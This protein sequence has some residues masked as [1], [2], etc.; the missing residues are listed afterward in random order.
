MSDVNTATTSNGKRVII[1]EDE[2]LAQAQLE[3]MLH[4]I[5]PSIEVIA[6][7]SSVEESRQFFSTGPAA[8]L[9]FVDIQLSDDHSFEIFRNVSVQLP[10]IFTTA[11]DEY[12]LQSFEHNAIDYLLK[13]ITEDKLRRSIAKMKSLELHFAKGNLEKLL[14]QDHRTHERIVAK[15]GAEFVSLPLRDIAYFYTE[16]KIVFLQEKRGRQYIMDKNLSELEQELDPTVFFRLN[17]KFVVNVEAIEKYRSDNG[18][19][20]VYLIPPRREDVFVS[21]ETA[22]EFRRWMGRY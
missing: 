9:V 3:A 19:I 21:K 20:R 12:L 17:R 7:L 10:L 8:D 1:I 2:M 11:Y 13:P 18:K 15:K 4:K 22:P 6:K 5:D 14:R 16:H